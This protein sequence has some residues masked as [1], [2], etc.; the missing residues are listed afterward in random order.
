MS[1]LLENFKSEKQK[2]WSSI[3]IEKYEEL[4]E[5][6]QKDRGFVNF[7]RKKKRKQLA[8]YNYE[9]TQLRE[10]L[11]NSQNELK[12]FIT[13]NLG[14]N[15][16]KDAL[17]LAKETKHLLKDFDVNMAISIK[18]QISTWKAMNGV[19]EKKIY[20]FKLLYKNSGLQKSINNA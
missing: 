13:K 17:K 2:G 18:N 5:Y 14:S 9:I 8:A 12:A 19:K 16:V 7:S 15:N 20:N 1:E 11:T 4:R 10:Y 3:T 6:V